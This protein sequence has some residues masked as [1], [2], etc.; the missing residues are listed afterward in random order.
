MRI[1]AEMRNDPNIT[2]PKLENNLGVGKTAIDRGIAALKKYG[3]IERVGSNKSGYWKIRK[4][5]V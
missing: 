4:D 5:E 2:K 1:L 3:Y